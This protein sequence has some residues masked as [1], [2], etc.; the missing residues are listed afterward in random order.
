VNVLAVLLLYH[1]SLERNMFITVALPCLVYSAAHRRLQVFHLCFVMLGVLCIN[2]TPLM[3]CL[4]VL[5]PDYS[6]P[7]WNAAS[8]LPLFL[9]EGAALPHADGIA[10]KCCKLE[11]PKTTMIVSLMTFLYDSLA[12]A[13]L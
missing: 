9:R 5:Q 12:V 4:Q 6:L 10:M 13:R 8:Q 3:P 2:S 7:T 11:A 1:L